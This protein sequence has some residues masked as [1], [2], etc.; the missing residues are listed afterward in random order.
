VVVSSIKLTSLIITHKNN[1]TILVV[2]VG[3]IKLT[4]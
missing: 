3:Y 4:P 2:V 1:F